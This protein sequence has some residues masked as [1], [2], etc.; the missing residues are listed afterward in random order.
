VKLFCFRCGVTR[1]I[2]QLGRNYY[3]KVCVGKNGGIENIKGMRKSKI[4]R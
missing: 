3:C 2:L 4:G 1:K